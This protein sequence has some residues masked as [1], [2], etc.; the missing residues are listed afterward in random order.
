MTIERLPSTSYDRSARFGTAA[1]ERAAATVVGIVDMDLPQIRELVGQA[2]ARAEADI[3]WYEKHARKK[4]FASRTCHYLGILLGVAGGL[5]P[6]L[7]VTFVAGWM[8]A[9]PLQAEAGIKSLGFILLALAAG[10]VLLDRVFGY[11]SSWMRY[12]LAQ[13]KLEYAL[14]RYRI[15]TSGL[16]A[17]DS[18][19]ADS[20]L[21]TAVFRA[22]E[23][24]SATVS[25]IVLSETEAWIS[26]H[27]AALLLEHAN[28]SDREGANAS[29]R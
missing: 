1:A 15:Q 20:E 27:N 19:T 3:R 11:S 16:L 5:C 6:L 8:A 17:T 10:V 2:I 23:N 14:E 22:T 21:A 9:E 18:N 28:R 4:A 25:G 12:K 13:M 26:Q 29:N 7:P 24:F